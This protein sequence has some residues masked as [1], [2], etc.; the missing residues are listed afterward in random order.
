MHHLADLGGQRVG[1]PGSCTARYSPTAR[2]GRYV[3]RLSEVVDAQSEHG[4][5]YQRVLAPNGLEHQLRAALVVDGTHWGLLHIE[6]RQPDFTSSEV[7]LIDALVPSRAGA[8]VQLVGFA[9][10]GLQQRAADVA[11]C[12]IRDGAATSPVVR[13]AAPRR[14]HRA[15]RVDGAARTA[16]P[17]GRE[18]SAAAPGRPFGQ[19]G[20]GPS[21]RAW[22]I[23]F[24]FSL[25]LSGDCIGR[26]SGHA[27]RGCGKMKASRG[28]RSGTL[29]IGRM[30]ERSRSVRSLAGPTGLNYQQV[31]GNLL[32]C[33]CVCW[34]AARQLNREPPAPASASDPRS[35]EDAAA[36]WKRNAVAS[37]G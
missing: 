19:P 13:H 23:A 14:R 27:T 7:A 29:E 18:Q 32:T 28:V 9:S 6:R 24:V 21:H 31:V 2:S 10:D 34:N 16:F 15:T 25:A 37:P 36:D 30:Q 5:V 33:A 4:P 26:R 17:E 20:A 11:D 35:L 8:A 12:S 1:R 22:T 3:A